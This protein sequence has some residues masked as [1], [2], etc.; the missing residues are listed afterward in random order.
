MTLTIVLLAVTLLALL[1][2]ALSSGLETGVYCLNRVRL[3]VRG[4]HD[5]ADAKRLARMMRRQEELVIT[6][7]AGTNLADYVASACVAAMLI[8]ANVSEN[9]AEVYATAILTPLI[10]VFGGII[11]KDL[12]QRKCDRLMYT[13]SAPLAWARQ[14]FAAIGLIQ[15]LGGLTHLLLRWIDPERVAEE[16]DLLPRARMQRLLIEGAARGG[17]TRYQRDTIDRVM[18]MSHV[19]LDEIMIARERAA[20]VPIDIARAELLRIAQ[21]AH[22]SRLP[23]FRPDTRH[24]VGIINVYDVLMDEHE[25]P[26]AE[27]VREAVFFLASD[28]APTALQ[29]LQAAREV[30]GIV[31]N[32][33]GECLGLF[34]MKDV[35]E[36]IVGELEAW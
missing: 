1:L 11:P 23:V 7:L 19:R 20:M 5:D 31:T 26:P 16:R 27:Y 15:L 34:T 36:C 33:R 24:V 10:L 29:R 25:R 21:M 28:T 3:R 12:F 22:F 4:E 17:L 14:V 30:I 2:S 8:H 6:T 35:A 9:L 32:A 13:L 18:K